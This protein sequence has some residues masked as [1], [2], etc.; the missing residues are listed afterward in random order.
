VLSRGTREAVFIALRLSLAAAYAR[1][2]VMLPLVL[3]DVL[4]NFDHDRAV[5][6]ARTLKTFSELGHQVLM[7]TCH[8]HIVDI[9][10]DIDVEVRILPTQGKPGRATVLLPEVFEEEEEYEEEELYEDVVEE[11]ELEQEPEPE[12]EIEVEVAE[13][14]EPEIVEEPP[15]VIAVEP[16]PEPKP[17]PRPEPSKPKKKARPRVEY[18]APQVSEVVEVESE[19]SPEIGWAW[20]EREPIERLGEVESALASIANHTLLDDANTD[21]GDVPPEV[22]DRNETWW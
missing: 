3:D 15:A 2:G 4:V 10:H 1:R 21:Q 7:F 17:K 14:E 19:L 11:P 22:W 13:E 20:F 8:Q 12:P 16:E 6:A 9:F 5:H 18:V